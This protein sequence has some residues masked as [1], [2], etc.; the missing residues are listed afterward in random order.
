MTPVASQ[1]CCFLSFRPESKEAEEEEEEEE[2]Q[3]EKP[4][5]VQCLLRLMS[6]PNRPY[7]SSLVAN[8]VLCIRSPPPMESRSPSVRQLWTSCRPCRGV[9]PGSSPMKTGLHLPATA[10]GPRPLVLNH[11]PC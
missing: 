8:K 3:E 6:S 2:E 5:I 10:E 4:I 7:P 1:P 9:C 11:N